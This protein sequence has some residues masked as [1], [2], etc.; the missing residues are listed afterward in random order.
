MERHFDRTELQKIGGPMQDR[1]QEE[2]QGAFASYFFKVRMY[3]TKSLT[4]AS[5]NLPL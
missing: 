3:F 5:V 1:R 4:W 2:K